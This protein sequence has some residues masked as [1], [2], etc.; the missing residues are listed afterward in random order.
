M[1]QLIGLTPIIAWLLIIWACARVLVRLVYRFRPQ[2]RG[3]LQQAY[4]NARERGDV[5][6][7]DQFEAQLRDMTPEGRLR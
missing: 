1:E 5:A 7:A 6:A 2:D 3:T 4:D